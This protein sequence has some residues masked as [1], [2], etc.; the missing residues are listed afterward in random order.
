MSEGAYLLTNDSRLK[1]LKDLKVKNFIT[2]S[3]EK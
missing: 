2:G 1:A 3:D